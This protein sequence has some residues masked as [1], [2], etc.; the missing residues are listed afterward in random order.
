MTLTELITEVYGITNRP[1]RVS[2]TLAGVRSATMKAHRSDFFPKDLYET[3]ITFPTSAY[4]QQIDYRTIIPRWRA[5]K[6]LR[7]FDPTAVPSPGLAGKFFKLVLPETVLDDYQ[8]DRENIWYLAGDV[9]QVRSCTE[10]QYA[11][12]G[13]YLNP[14][15]GATDQLFN[16]WIAEEFPWSIIHNAASYVFRAIGKMDESQAQ[17]QLGAM[18]MAEL[19]N[20][21][22]VAEGF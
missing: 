20:S 3:G 13:C 11:L 12:L 17:L 14:Q 19:I 9:L 7:H 2:E 5:A 4:Y 6:Y 10:F 18:E 16:S 22:I 15:A 1:D 8:I 21:N